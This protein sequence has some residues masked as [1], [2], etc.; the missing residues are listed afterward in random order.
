[1]ALPVD[2]STVLPELLHFLPLHSRTDKSSDLSATTLSPDN[3]SD[4]LELPVLLVSPDG[5]AHTL[6]TNDVMARTQVL[7]VTSKPTSLNL[8][9]VRGAQSVDDNLLL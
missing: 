7:A 4:L 5:A 1:V 2:G 6:P 9:E 3:A 8:D